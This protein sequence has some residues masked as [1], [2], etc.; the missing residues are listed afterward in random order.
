MIITEILLKVALHAITL[1]IKVLFD[2][3]TPV[4]RRAVLCVWVRRAGVHTITLVLY[5]RSLPNL[6]T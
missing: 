4:S 1:R 6:A 5:I 3:Y 2:F